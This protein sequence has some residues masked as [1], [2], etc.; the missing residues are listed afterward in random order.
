LFIGNCTGTLHIAAAVNIPIVAI[1]ASTSAQQWAPK[2]NIAVVQ[3]EILPC[4]PCI[5]HLAP[6]ANNYRCL[7]NT[8]V[9]DVLAACVKIL[10]RSKF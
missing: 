3:K 8:K 1:Y 5:E 6:C 4:C 7:T 2:H 10:E 9:D